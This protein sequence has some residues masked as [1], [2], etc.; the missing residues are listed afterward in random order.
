MTDMT[1]E[2]QPLLD[3][4]QLE[5]APAGGSLVVYQRGHCVATLSYGMAQADT[6]WNADTLSLNYSTG[7]GVLATLVHILVSAGQLNYDQPIADLWP[8]FANNGKRHI[9]LREVLTH[10]AGLFDVSSLVDDGLDLLSWEQMLQR[11][12]NMPVAASIELS[13]AANRRWRESH[14]LPHSE[15]AREL[16]ESPQ[17][18]TSAGHLHKPH[19]QS[20]YSALVYGWVIGGLIEAA[21]GESLPKVLEQYLTG[22]LG[23]ADACYFGVPKKELH[24]VAKLPQDFVVK[25]DKIDPQSSANTSANADERKS[26]PRS[27]VDSEQT[28]QFYRQ[29]SLYSC[30]RARASQLQSVLADPPSTAQINRL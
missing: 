15:E 6:P 29:L 5:D 3:Q 7:K 20:V 16:L 11:V 21:V 14:A 13:S 9:T 27:K 25:E 26:R 1:D 2:L 23:I 30:W 28:Q 12:A 19:Y 22:P 10:Q 17:S 8:E 24:R 4:L 18:Q